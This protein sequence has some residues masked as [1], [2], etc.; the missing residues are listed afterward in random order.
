MFFKFQSVDLLSL[1]SFTT[2]I[3]VVPVVHVFSYS[4]FDSQESNFGSCKKMASEI[5]YWNYVRK[6]NWQKN[7]LAW[8]STYLFYASILCVAVFLLHSVFAVFLLFLLFICEH[9]DFA[10][11]LSLSHSLS[12]SV[13][14]AYALIHIFKFIR[15]TTNY[16]DWFWT[17][18]AECFSFIFL[19]IL[20][21]IVRSTSRVE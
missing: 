3:N 16:H 5:W 8:C 15:I 4:A 10:T 11:V 7:G 14:L 19:E 20:N 9:I 2:S 12:L 21:P 1:S 6:E 13:W 17:R 18:I